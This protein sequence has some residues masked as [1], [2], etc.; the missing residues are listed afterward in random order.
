MLFLLKRIFVF[1]SFIFI[2]F[3]ETIM[4]Q[5]SFQ[6]QWIGLDHA[7]K[8][9]NIWT[10]YRKEITLQA[11]PLSAVAQIATDSKYWLWINGKLVVKDGELKRGPKPE[12]T[13]YD[14]INLAKFL[15]K[16][17][18]TIAVLTWYWGK[19]AFSHKTSEK[20]ALLFQ[21]PDLQLIS[22]NTWKVARHP[23][24]F[25]PDKPSPN[26][27]LPETNV[28]FDAAK[29]INFQSPSFNASAWE[30]AKE[31]GLP[32]VKPWGYLEKR[33][34][35]FWKNSALLPYPNDKVL[36]KKSTGDTIKAKLPYN[37]Q[38]YPYFKIKAPAGQKIHILTDQYFV[39]NNKEFASVRTEYIT[40]EG[41]QEFE[42]PNWMSGHTVC[43]VF[44]AGVEIMLLRYVETGYPTEFAG[45]F[46]CNDEFLNKLWQKAQR[47]LY[48]NMRDTYMDCPDRERG[49][50]WGDAAIEFQ[51]AFYAF[52]TI[53]NQLTRKCIYNLVDWQKE[54]GILYS[55][56]PGS[57]DKELPLQGLAAVYSLKNYYL[58]T[59]DVQTIKYAYPAVKKY[60]DL[61]KLGS[62]GLV[63]HRK[64]DWD[65]AD[66][67]DN[68]D[69][70]LLDNAWLVLALQTA[71]DMAKISEQQADVAGYD[72]KIQSIKANFNKTFWNG[73][74]YRSKAYKGKTDDRGNAM[75][76]LAGFAEPTKYDAIKKVLAEQT[77]ASPYMEKY[78]LESLYL[79]NDP[80]AAIN[81]MRDRYTPMVNAE[82]STLWELFE[83]QPNFATNNHGWTG[84]PLTLL[85]QYAAGLTPDK[86]GY[87][88][89]I[90]LP[91]PGVL[92]SV[93]TITKTVK[94]DFVIDI[95]KSDTR[96]SVTAQV[97]VG[98][99]IGI[100]KML[101]G[102]KIPN[103]TANGQPLWKMGK[104]N[105]AN[106]FKIKFQEKPDYYLFQ[107]PAGKVVIEAF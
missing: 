30:N 86:K 29:D 20:T 98:G 21:C 67:G 48:V 100:P 1:V 50:W 81:R 6:A 22:N 85:S 13:Y 71:S 32:P 60:L 88:S 15:I 66:W 37:A 75:A 62:D 18:N 16:G 31:Y 78:V 38:V 44:P 91:Q 99:F 79:M 89:F 59:G 3:P 97:P 40:K 19:S 35:P 69:A 7:E 23:S 80:D 57:W 49:L 43:Y 17:K 94:G 61:W 101:N 70:P 107:V 74:A 4:A 52:D 24:Y 87:E 14:E 93:N 73:T 102:K 84:G 41:V 76:V 92:S 104:F 56:T 55:P 10:C 103:I 83:L 95:K 27:R 39:A 46:T 96:F 54:N 8:D 5:E 106:S 12:G 2:V 105:G 68:I 26:F 58:Y 34:I 47:T 9:T 11:V 51:E 65:W 36:A 77:N 42:C 82:T 90:L 53:P 64:G 63:V 25:S 28:G 33:N 72:K 45:K